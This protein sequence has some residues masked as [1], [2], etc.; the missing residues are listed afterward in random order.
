MARRLMDFAS[1][2]M[3]RF[4]G[5]L[6]CEYIN[7]HALR[8]DLRI[9]RGCGYFDRRLHAA[10][11]EKQGIQ[12]RIQCF[13]YDYSRHNRA[14]HTAEQ[15]HDRSAPLPREQFPSLLCLWRGFCRAY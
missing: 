15:H 12:Q 5:G 6:V 7:L 14:S 4:P 1:T 3:S 11:D 13:R 8:V 9:G 2:L 10:G